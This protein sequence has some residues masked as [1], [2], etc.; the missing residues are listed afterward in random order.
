MQSICKLTPGWV[1]MGDVDGYRV[2]VQD[3]IR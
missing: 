3:N 1:G 2:V